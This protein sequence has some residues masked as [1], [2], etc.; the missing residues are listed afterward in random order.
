MLDHPVCF[1]QRLLPLICRTFPHIVP[2]CHLPGNPRT[3]P[4][5]RYGCQL[6]PTGARY[7][8]AARKAPSVG[9]GKGC[10]SPR[11]RQHKPSFARTWEV[12]T[13]GDRR[14]SAAA[15]IRQ[16]LVVAVLMFVAGLGALPLTGV[17]GQTPPVPSD[18]T[19]H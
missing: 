6:E 17:L 5:T 1:Q 3:D 7:V 8:R 15:P 4:R 16:V 19:I 9:I 13:M 18:Y 2:S 14:S 10:P 11:Q 12:L